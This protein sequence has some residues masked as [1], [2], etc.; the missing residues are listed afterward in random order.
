MSK[1]RL[2][3]KFVNI[4]HLRGF[5]VKYLPATN[6]QGSRV[7]IYD[8]RHKKGIIISYR[9]DLNGVN[10]IALDFL[11]NKR[12]INIVSYS[13]NDKKGVYNILTDDFT[14][15]LKGK[16]EFYI[17]NDK[18]SENY[19]FKGETRADARHFI[20]NHCDLSKNWSVE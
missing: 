8:T 16:S 10:E 7:K 20:V 17:Y 6:Y 9:Y 18:D 13:Y 2:K 1:I 4:P 12:N 15:Q 3:D 11:I 14:T 5:E 19:T